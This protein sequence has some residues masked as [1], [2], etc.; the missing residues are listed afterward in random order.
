MGISGNYHAEEHTLNHFRSEFF[1]PLILSRS[2]RSNWESQGGKNLAEK[3]E[4]T[5]EEL[6][7]NSRPEMLTPDQD[8]DIRKIE[9]R[10]IQH[11][12]V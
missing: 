9:E 5:A 7:Q 11:S 2:N 8:R 10:F 6:M 3:A 4:E 1:E 12:L